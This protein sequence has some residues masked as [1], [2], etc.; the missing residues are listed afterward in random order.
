MARRKKDNM[1]PDMKVFYA[2]YAGMEERRE[3]QKRHYDN[4]EKNMPW[5]LKI[6][7]QMMDFQSGWQFVVTGFDK[8]PAGKY[9]D[10][11]FT[12]LPPKEG[13]R[14]NPEAY[15]TR[16]MFD[17]SDPE[18]RDFR[19]NI[20]STMKSVEDEGQW[21][22]RGYTPDKFKD[23]V[24]KIADWIVKAYGEY[25]DKFWSNYLEESKP[26]Y[27][28][29]RKAMDNLDAP[30]S[31][32]R[33][34]CG[35][36]SNCESVGQGKVVFYRYCVIRKSDSTESGIMKVDAEQSACAGFTQKEGS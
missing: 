25:G 3:Q 24:L 33:R 27:A 36:C 22:V 17:M 9:M 34:I 10:V 20:D 29:A 15:L 8:H 28:A 7:T 23:G 16:T 2:K 13:E 12:A 32:C 11:K 26:L 6:G 5:W 19:W 4:L 1:S 21:V 18:W 14:R 35:Q 31:P 30:E